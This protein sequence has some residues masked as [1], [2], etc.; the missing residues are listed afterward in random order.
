MSR[1]YRCKKDKHLIE[2]HSILR[3]WNYYPS[4]EYY[5]F[6]PNS[7]E[8]RKRLAK[9][10]SDNACYIRNWHGPSWYHN[11]YSQRPYRRDCK[12]QIQKCIKYDYD[13]S[14]LRKPKRI[15]FY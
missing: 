12:K 4:L 9:F 10:H 7:K 13:I 8:G 6:E 2:Y 11:L 15:Y 1:T 14:M 3:D 5:I